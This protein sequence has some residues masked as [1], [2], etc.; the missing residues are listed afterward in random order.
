MRTTLLSFKVTFVVT[1]VSMLTLVVHWLTCIWSIKEANEYSEFP[2]TWN[3]RVYNIPIE[4]NNSQFLPKGF[5]GLIAALPYAAWF[6]IAVEEVPL[7]GEDAINPIKNI[8]KAL[9]CSILILALCALL[10]LISSVS[11]LGGSSNIALV[12]S[13]LVDSFLSALEPY[14]EPYAGHPHLCGNSTLIMKQCLTPT[15]QDN[16]ACKNDEFKYQTQTQ[17]SQAFIQIGTFFGLFT[18]TQAIIYAGG[19]QIFSLTRNG[20]LS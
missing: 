18:S 20:V 12:G 1:T 7:S 11:V 3:Q 17:L 19:R 8:P 9:V 5:G 6:F 13:P 16:Y 15:L 10:T 4:G 14:C 2:S